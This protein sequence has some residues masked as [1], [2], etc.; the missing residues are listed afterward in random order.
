[1]N[2]YNI[3]QRI[4]IIII[5]NKVKY[6]LSKLNYLFKLLTHNTVLLINIY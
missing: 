6:I 1:M 3:I 5:I 4:I 2:K